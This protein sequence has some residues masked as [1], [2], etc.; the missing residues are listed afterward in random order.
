M[1]T[2]RTTRLSRRILFGVPALIAAAAAAVGLTGRPAQARPRAVEC[3]ADLIE[4]V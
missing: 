2:A 4:T 1:D 3:V